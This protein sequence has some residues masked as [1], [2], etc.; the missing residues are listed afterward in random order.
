MD[1]WCALWFW[2]ISQADLL[3]KR[4]DFIFEMDLILRGTMQ[5]NAVN[6]QTNLFETEDEDDVLIQ[7]VNLDQLCNLFPRLALV[8][9]IAQQNHFMH[10]ELEFADLFAERGGFDLVIGNPPWIKITWN[11][12]NYLSE[13]HPI[14]AIRSLN[15]AETAKHRIE[16][17][18]TEV[19]RDGYLNEYVAMTGEQAFLNAT[20]NYAELKGQQT[21]LF[22]CFLPQAWN[23]GTSKGVSAF[24]H[25][26]GVFDDPKGGILRRILYPKLRYHFQFENELNLFEGTNDHGRMRFSLNV[27]CN[28][29]TNKFDVISNLFAPITIEECYNGTSNEMIPGIKDEKENWNIKGHPDRILSIGKNELLLFANL[30]DGNSEW[31]E[32]RLPVLHSSRLLRV[33]KC[34]AKQ[35]VTIEKLGEDVSATVMWDE[36]YAQ[37][38][39]TTVKDE[40]FPAIMEDMIYSGPHIGIANPV[41]KSARKPCDSNGAYDCIDLE[42]IDDDYIQRCKYR[43]KC[44]L[45]EYNRRAPDTPWGNKY[46]DNYRI[47]SRKMLNLAGER[48]LISTII[49]PRAGHILTTFGIALKDKRMVPVVCGL[50]ISLP[51]DFYVKTLGNASFLFNVAKRLPI[52]EGRLMKELIVRSLRLNAVSTRYANL[53]NACFDDDFRKCEWSKSDIRLNTYAFDKLNSTWDKNVVLRNDYARR[54]ALV[55]IDV[56]VSM[57]LG[58]TLKELISTYQIQFPVLHSN[59]ADTW[60]DTSGRIAFTSNKGIG[61][62]GYDRSEWE[63]GI[64]GAPAGQKFYRTITD[65]TM[66]GGPVERTIEYVA[67]FD[68]CDREQDYETAWKF[69]EEKYGKRI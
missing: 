49:P 43:P 69:F 24:V 65:D 53:W 22:K 48:T 66:P 37:R 8:R 27:Y 56:L 9:E 47:L 13:S 44:S 45:D 5:T 46:H 52:L 32:A 59:E 4:S 58:M 30:F 2:P 31:Q 42:V 38:D 17:L 50:F 64:K 14:L 10:W 40:H 11:E 41:F 33:L 68:R 63:N 61:G 6:K 60:Y 16:A 20:H 28:T 12:Q 54:Y 15:A 21:N 29:E 25:P 26:N 67:P 19:I 39:G 62:V 23:L 55:E 34:F 3:P 35:S 36:T 7:E 18:S 1:Y 57:M 51:Y